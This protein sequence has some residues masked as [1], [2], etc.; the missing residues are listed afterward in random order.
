MSGFGSLARSL[1]ISCNI[2]AFN[3]LL[4]PSCAVDKSLSHSAQA[5]FSCSHFRL[6]R[7]SPPPHGKAANSAT[8]CADGISCAQLFAV[9]TMLSIRRIKRE[10]TRLDNVL[11][12]LV[13]A[14]DANYEAIES[15]AAFHRECTIAPHSTA[16]A[17]NNG[18]QSL[19]LTSAIVLCVSGALRNYSPRFPIRTPEA[20]SRSGEK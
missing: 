6:S 3:I 4:P 7:N 12:L 20:N 1:F 11:P 16:T 18:K 5:S 17:L 10:T 13:E 8:L 19:S 15:V 14:F 2:I 9:F